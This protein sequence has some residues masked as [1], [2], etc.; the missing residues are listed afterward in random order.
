MTDETLSRQRPPQDPAGLVQ[1]CR[2]LHTAIDAL[3]AKAAEAAGITRNDLRCLNLLEHGPTSP[4]EISAALE[5]TSGSVTA[6]I[7]RLEKSSYVKRIP[8]PDDR[9]ALLIELTPAI[10]GVLAGVY[11]PLGQA[12]ADLASTYGG[13]RAAEAVVHINDVSAVFERLKDQ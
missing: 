2:R 4:K 13:D 5:L 7:D 10:Y 6:M 1:A 3:D 11:R 9:R 12:I 8:H